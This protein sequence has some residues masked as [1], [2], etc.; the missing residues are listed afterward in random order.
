MSY[1]S[2]LSYL[3]CLICLTGCLSWYQVL[4]FFVHI[5]KRLMLSI[6]FFWFKNIIHCAYLAYLKKHALCLCFDHCVLKILYLVLIWN[7]WKIYC[8]CDLKLFKDIEPLCLS[9]EKF[10]VVLGL[11]SLLKVKFFIKLNSSPWVIYLDLQ[12]D[13]Q[14]GDL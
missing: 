12:I 3:T 5:W 10:N 14:L 1:L 11:L 8:V 13:C 9:F 7:I 6:W 2:T 4:V